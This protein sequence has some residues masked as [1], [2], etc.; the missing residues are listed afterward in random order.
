MTKSKS[1]QKIW[2]SDLACRD[3]LSNYLPDYFDFV[4]RVQNV[5]QQCLTNLA[6]VQCWFGPLISACH[7]RL[8][9]Y[10]SSRHNK[11]T[12]KQ[13]FVKLER[14]RK[15][16]AKFRQKAK[17]PPTKK[18]KIK[19]KLLTVVKVIKTSI[20]ARTKNNIRQSINQ[21]AICC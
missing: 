11:K 3:S 5:W 2:K 16:R 12:A 13:Q 20:N 19:W 17:A 6:T 1:E 7:P 8:D 21:F 18:I 15:V 10:F 9:D 4:C 14:K